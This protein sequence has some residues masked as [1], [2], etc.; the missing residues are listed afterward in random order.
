MILDTLIEGYQR[1]CD[2]KNGSSITSNYRA[3]SLPSFLNNSFF[4]KHISEHINGNL[5]KLDT[6]REDYEKKSIVQEPKPFQKL[7]Y[8]YFPS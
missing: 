7:L 2:C 4:V 6:L 8:S 5:M 3:I 1:L